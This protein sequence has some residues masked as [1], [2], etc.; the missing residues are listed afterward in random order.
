M[1]R[2]SYKSIAW[3][4]ALMMALSFSPVNAVGSDF[5]GTAVKTVSLPDVM[6]FTTADFTE[7]FKGNKA[8]LEAVVITG[9]DPAFGALKLEDDSALA[10]RIDMEEI[11]DGE[12]TFVP[13]DTGEVAYVVTAY[14]YGGEGS[15]GTAVLEITVEESTD[16][17]NPKY[18]IDENMPVRL[19]PT[20]FSDL[21]SEANG[22][23]L[24]YVKFELPSAG[25]GV[26][27]F[28]YTS[29]ALYEAKVL[30]TTKYYTDTYPNISRVSFVPAEDFSGTVSIPYTGYTANHTTYWGM[31]TIE[32]RDTGAEDDAYKDKEEDEEEDDEESED[33]EHFSDVKK[34]IFWAVEAIDYLYDGGILL[35]DGTG[36]YNPQASISRGD[37]MMMLSRAFDIDGDFEDNF[38]D[39]EEDDYYYEAV[40]AAKKLGITKGSNGRFNPRSALSRQDAM[41]LILRALDVADIEL[42]DGDDDDLIPFKDKDKVPEYAREAFRALVQAGIIEGSGKYLNPSSSVSR[43]EIAVIL[44]RILTM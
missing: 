9:T 38:S 36:Y 11:Q 4:L 1:K 41:V 32:V 17:G 39:V 33:S 14:A 37:F 10:E 5:S 18:T 28:D 31:L 35:G 2:K 22:R 27:Y 23:E 44:H 26:L 20:Y 13:D 3:V 40:G 6:T 30:E 19:S 15:V 8:D 16:A 24:S 25:K 34:N 21:F 43:A 29:P 7:L 42:E 12:L